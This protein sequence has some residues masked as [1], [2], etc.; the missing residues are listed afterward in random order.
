MLAACSGETEPPPITSATELVPFRDFGQSTLVV[1][2][3]HEWPVMVAD[4]PDLRAL[5]LMNVTDLGPWAGMVFEWDE[6]TDGGFWM[7]N[8]LIPLTVYWLDQHGAIVGIADMVPCPPE[9]E[10]CPHWRPGTAYVT[11][12]EVPAG[13]GQQL[14]ISSE[15]ILTF[16]D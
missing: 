14:G 15:S 7:R 1:D 8:T 4:T 5:G 6:P 11:A 12:L 2:G 9:E 13:M 3:E 10:D 16:R